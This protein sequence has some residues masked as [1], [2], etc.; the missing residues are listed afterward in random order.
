[1]DNIEASRQRP[2][3]HAQL[4]QRTVK[5]RLGVMMAFLIIPI[6][7]WWVTVATYIEQNTGDA[8]NG[9]F[10][11]GFVGKAYA[12]G[13]LGA[14]ISPLIWGAVADRY[15]AAERIMAA[16]QVAAAFLLWQLTRVTTEQGWWWTMLA[17]AFCFSPQLGLANAVCFRHLDDPERTFP[18]IR[19]ILTLSW[20]MGGWIVGYVAPWWFGR[21][22]EATLLPMQIGIVFH[23]IAAVACLVVP[24]TPPLPVADGEGKTGGGL[25]RFHFQSLKAVFGSELALPV[26]AMTLLAVSVQFYMHLVHVFLSDNQVKG[27]LG[28]LSWGQVTEIG[29]VLLLPLAFS[30]MGIKWVLVVGGTCWCVRFLLLWAAESTTLWLYWPSIL[31]HG[32]CFSFTYLAIQIYADRVSPPGS[33]ASIQGLI[34]FLMS[35]VGALLG[36]QFTSWTQVHFLPAGGEYNWRRV[37]ILAAVLAAIPTVMMLFVRSSEPQIQARSASE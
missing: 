24:S 27:A 3:L 37:W 14:M 12:T 13:A 21:S 11:G 30:R 26:V 15:I 35:G 19:A 9:M 1:M 2:N 8:G 28:H 34:S 36:S 16:L 10:S 25:R 7:C 31:L 32:I 4:D 20:V 18:P 22:I 6:S 33:R 29:F 5:I 23:L 17:W